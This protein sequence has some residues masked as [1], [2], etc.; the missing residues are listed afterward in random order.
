MT[1]AGI[2]GTSYDALETEVAEAVRAVYGERLVSLVVFG[3]VGRRSPRPGSDM[4]LLLVC[5][6]LPRGRPARVEEFRS[7]EKRLAACL[8]K[9]NA[10]GLRV[11]L[12]PVF[13]TPAEAQRGSPL[14]L[15]MV[16]DG[17][18]LFD[19][20]GFM[21]GVLRRL[22]ARLEALGARRVRRGNAWFWDLKPD[23]RVGEV[24][25]L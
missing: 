23:F 8:E 5:E 11:E 12:S 13:K 7:V 22:A 15:D 3:S 1:G 20:G 14:F 10:S 9:M 2:V 17:R 18:V 21:Q 4:D 25:D 16:E 24:F 19:R 6:P